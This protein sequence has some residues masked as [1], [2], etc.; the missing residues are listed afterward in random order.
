MT[1]LDS[2]VFGVATSGTGGNG[3]VKYKPGL[4]VE[5]GDEVKSM[6]DLDVYVRWTKS[7]AMLQMTKD[8]ADDW[9]N[10]KSVVG[11]CPIGGV[12][13]TIKHTQTT[14]VKNGLMRYKG[15]LYIYDD[16]FTT[17]TFNYPIDLANTIY[18]DEVDKVYLQQIIQY[19]DHLTG[20]EKFNIAGLITGDVTPNG[21]VIFYADQTPQDGDYAGVSSAGFYHTSGNGIYLLSTYSSNP[22]S[23]IVSLDDNVHFWFNRNNDDFRTIYITKNNFQTIET[24]TVSFT[25][26]TIHGNIYTIA[27]LVKTDSN[28]IFL[29]FGNFNT[30]GKKE[31]TGGYY[32]SYHTNPS[33]VF[34]AELHFENNYTQAYL[35]NV[36]Y[37]PHYYDSSK[38]VQGHVELASIKGD[39]IAVKHGVDNIFI[40]DVN[41]SNLLRIVEPSNIASVNNGPCAG[42]KIAYDHENDDVYF[43]AAKDDDYSVNCYKYN[44][45]T[46]EVSEF[47]LSRQLSTGNYIYYSGFGGFII[48]DGNFVGFTDPIPSNYA[49]RRN[50][51]KTSLT[52][53]SAIINRNSYLEATGIKSLH[54]VEG[55]TGEYIYNATVYKIG[56]RYDQIKY[57][58]PQLRTYKLSQ[59]TVI[60]SA[61]KWM[62]YSSTNAI[63]DAYM[64]RI[65]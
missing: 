65:F 42:F 13:S 1:T 56:H 39:K 10:F 50:H 18:K 35:T 48:L 9:R 25:G 24:I 40:Y 62:P 58:G 14:T 63:E 2:T 23:R 43:A 61:F 5:Y 12:T 30:T 64:L 29:S 17:G 45:V 57:V 3:V 46:N 31:L 44:T 60:Y 26:L 11:L 59:H 22:P 37:P 54:L 28:R 20:I 49:F 33:I 19:D 51:F 21:R 34:F 38:N 32:S 16:Y 4:V 15:G 7:P 27:S 53:N 36:I 6:K 55:I 52:V 47:K 41:T 8:P